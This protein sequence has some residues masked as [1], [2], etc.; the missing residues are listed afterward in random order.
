MNTPQ[1]EELQ[2]GRQFGIEA[3]DWKGVTWGA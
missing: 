3:K 1:E 2:E